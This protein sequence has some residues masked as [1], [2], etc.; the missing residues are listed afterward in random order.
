MSGQREI[1]VFPFTDTNTLF[2]GFM[3]NCSYPKLNLSQNS[4]FIQNNFCLPGFL[5]ADFAD[6][7]YLFSEMAKSNAMKFL[8]RPLR[9]LC[10]CLCALCVNISRNLTP[11]KII[12]PQIFFSQSRQAAKLSSRRLPQILPEGMPS[13][14]H[15]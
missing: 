3:N 10:A 4:R 6:Y 9:V 5:L 14:H 13:A 15:S 8:L 12:F 2:T 1:H 7:Q 11:S